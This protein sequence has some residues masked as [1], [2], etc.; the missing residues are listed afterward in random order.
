[1]AERLPTVPV[2][3]FAGGRS[4]I[5]G[6]QFA[7]VDR[8]H[9]GRYGIV[10]SEEGYRNLHRF[11]FGD[12][13]VTAYLVGVRDGALA[14]WATWRCNLT[15][16]LRDPVAAGEPLADD[17]PALGQW[18]K[19]MLLPGP[20]REFLGERAAIRLT[21]EGRQGKVAAALAHS[22]GRV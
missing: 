2:R 18:V 11:L 21:V 10:S 20:A 8:R 19:R 9:I 4:G 15:L 3:G 6:A 13:E 14:A 17:G 7:F 22:D 1:M 5:D 12:L 16:P